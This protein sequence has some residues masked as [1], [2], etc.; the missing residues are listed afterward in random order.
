MID[1]AQAIDKATELFGT[2]YRELLDTQEIIGLLV[3]EAELSADGK[4]WSITLSFSRRGVEN[5]S[6]LGEALGQIN[7]KLIRHLKT[8]RIDAETGQVM[9]MKIKD[10]KSP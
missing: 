3:E 10:P 1:V 8:F 9:A 4:V 5:P 7:P 2:I 6:T